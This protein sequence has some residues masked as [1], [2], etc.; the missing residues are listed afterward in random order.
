MRES[1]GE[2]PVIA[3]LLGNGWFFRKDS[4]SGYGD[5]FAIGRWLITMLCDVGKT[6]CNH[7]QSV[8]HYRHF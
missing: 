2:V 5:G 6:T 8:H 7:L 4:A 1:A 3:L